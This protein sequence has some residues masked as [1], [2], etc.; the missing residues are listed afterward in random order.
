MVCLEIQLF[1]TK[2]LYQQMFIPV[3]VIFIPFTLYTLSCFCN[4]A[5]EW[6]KS[7]ITSVIPFLFK[8]TRPGYITDY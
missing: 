2:S 4:S 6:I 5:L 3:Q 8:R 1:I 7:G